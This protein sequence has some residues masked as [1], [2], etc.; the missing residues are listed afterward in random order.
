M[1]LLTLENSLI[2]ADNLSSLH[3]PFFKYNSAISMV[4]LAFTVLAVAL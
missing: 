4:L 3:S 2:R 1:A